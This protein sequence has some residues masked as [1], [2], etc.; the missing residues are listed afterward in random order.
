[1]KKNILLTVLLVF[2]FLNFSFSEDFP[3]EVSDSFAGEEPTINNAI[4]E[5]EDSAI[6]KIAETYL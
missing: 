4:V 3:Y 2:S 6:K 1:M 5:N